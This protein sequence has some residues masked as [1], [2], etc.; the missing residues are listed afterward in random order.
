MEIRT[1]MK[2]SK[3]NTALLLG[4]IVLLVSGISECQQFSVSPEAGATVILG[5]SLPAEECRVCRVGAVNG[6]ELA[7]TSTLTLQPDENVILQYNCSSPHEA[8]TVEIQKTIECT[9][10]SCSPATGETQPSLFSDLKRTFIWTLTGPPETQLG[11]DFPVDGLKKIEPS[12]ACPDQ[13]QFTVISTQPGGDVRTEMFCRNGPVSHVDLPD[14]ATVSLQV[15]G[16]EDVNP[17]LFEITS[18]PL[19]K[20]SR[21][22]VVAPE[23]DTTINIKRV[24]EESDC[25]VCSN[26]GSEPPQ[27]SESLKLAST[28]NISVDFTCPQPQDSF[29]V[30]IIRDIECTETCS[31]D[32]VVGEFPHFAEFNRTFTWYLKAPSPLNAF[33][34]N[35][36]EPGMKQVLSSESCPDQLSYNIIQFQR[37]GL[38]PIGTFCRNG[39]ITNVQV[40]Y[41]GQ[42]SVEVPGGMEVE[43][44]TFKVLPGS[45]IKKLAVV[46][47]KLPARP[48][49]T[50]L[51]SVNYP[52]DFPDDDLMMWDFTVPS[53]YNYS[54]EFLKYSAPTCLKKGVVVEYKRKGGRYTF[55]SKLTDTQ[56]QDQ[57]GSFTMSLTNCETDHRGNPPGLS[58]N[59]QVSVIKSSHPTLCTVDLQN[60]PDLT[61]NIE[62]TTTESLCEMKMDGVLK[63][64]ITVLP[65]TSTKLFFQDCPSEELLLTISKTIGCHKWEECPVGGTLLNLPAL[66]QCLPAPMESIT[67]RLNVPEDGTVDLLPSTISLRQSLPSQKCNRIYSVLVAET[68][69]TP[70]GEFC[71]KGPISKVQIHAN[72]TVTVAPRALGRSRASFFNVTFS[73]EITESYIFTLSPK[74]GSPAVVS[75]PNWPDSMRPYSTASWIV[76]LPPRYAA[77]VFFT[78]LSLPKCSYRHTS[79]RVQTLGSLEEMF[80]RRE[81]EEHVDK[82]SV[83]D[84]FYLN[85]SN[86]LP[87]E[88]EFSLLSKITLKKK[89]NTLLAIILGTVG[90]LLLLMLIVLAAVC[91]VIRKKKKK[92]AEQASIY[93]PKGNIFR[94]PD[95]NFPKSRGNNDS[96]VY[97]SIEDTMV[98]G[99]LLQNPAYNGPVTDKYGDVFRPVDGDPRSPIGVE[100]ASGASPEA[101]VYRPFLDP[102]QSMVPPRP[103]TPVDRQGSL[104]FVDRRMVDNELNTF[105]ANGDLTPLRLSTIEPQPEPEP[106]P[107]LAGDREEEDYI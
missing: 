40:L 22:M 23:L 94:P 49:A 13:Y 71:P 55:G 93:I 19:V 53:N 42:V 18:K 30:E 68:D 98:Y 11:L 28:Q 96:H 7:C 3:T 46:N 6:S 48:V 29:T 15:L 34:L 20:R 73:R 77:E 51:F 89:S 45:E 47:V 90:G 87:E 31:G 10:D 60:E 88:G 83:P 4:T 52:N 38:L 16:K 78:N 62:K 37:A 70:F 99:H 5:T 43:P 97:A 67:W 85:T 82:L 95:G 17:T 106:E 27:C 63:D 75:T 100:K 64:K 21:K 65:G 74:V 24:V 107:D 66:P 61:I 32:I 54:V 92:M 69:G 104:G 58:L 59:F 1:N 9:K 36:L 102:S 12:E 57:Q 41:R 14:K 86:C 76:L 80:S 39:A 8:F 103:H 25:T 26:E 2:F 105:K 44:D 81:D 79:I 84:S 91:V 101:D 72:V 35:F 50:E 56:P 33:Q